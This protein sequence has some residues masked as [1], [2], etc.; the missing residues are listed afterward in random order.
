M[1]KTPVN[2]TQKGT[3]YGLQVHVMMRRAGERTECSGQALNCLGVPFFTVKR[4]SCQTQKGTSHGVGVHVDETSIAEED[5]I[6]CDPPR[7]IMQR[8]SFELL[9]GALFYGEEAC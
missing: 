6:G 1:V 3:P 5:A 4:P 7:N 2:H 8:A 9:G